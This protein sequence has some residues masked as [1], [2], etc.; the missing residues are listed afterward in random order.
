MIF[1]CFLDVVIQTC[2]LHVFLSSS[3]TRTKYTHMS[4]YIQK[5]ECRLIAQDDK[6]TKAD[7]NCIRQMKTSL[8]ITHSTHA[9][10]RQN[11]YS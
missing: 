10:H 8:K 11:Q 6:L 1:F 4:V 2:H 3:K 9:K 5:H 7:R